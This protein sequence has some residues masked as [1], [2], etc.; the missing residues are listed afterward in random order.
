MKSGQLVAVSQP[1]MHALLSVT[2]VHAQG[3]WHHR[4]PVA[5]APHAEDGRCTIR[6]A[7]AYN[8]QADTSHGKQDKACS[9]VGRGSPQS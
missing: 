5:A 4:R 3:F 7:E 2:P 9:L 8:E 1:E 6:G